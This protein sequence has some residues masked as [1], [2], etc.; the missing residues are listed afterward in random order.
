[1]VGL[2]SLALLLRFEGWPT[3]VLGAR[4]STFTL[5]IAAQAADSAGVVVTS[6]ESRNLPQ[7]IVALLAVD[8]L[9][10]PVFF[11]GNAFE[12]EHTRRQLPGHYLGTR[13]QG[14]CAQLIDTLAR[15]VQDRSAA[16]QSPGSELR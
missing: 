10:I 5:T 16:I 15:A 6:T 2:E 1:M 14:A 9:G 12:P 3:R 8:A 13:M 4:V 7:A 11:V